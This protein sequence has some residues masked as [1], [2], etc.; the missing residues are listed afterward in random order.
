M[1]F[2]PRTVAQVSK[3]AVS[4]I[5]K[6]AGCK[7]VWRRANDLRFAGLETC[8]TADLEVRATTQLD[9]GAVIKMHTAKISQP[10]RTGHSGKKGL[11]QPHEQ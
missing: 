3:P 11:N 7:N 2:D 6:S 1:G 9:L 5:S 10:N 8:D 4:P